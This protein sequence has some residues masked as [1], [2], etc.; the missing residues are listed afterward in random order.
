MLHVTSDHKHGPVIVGALEGAA[1]A[2]VG[3]GVLGR[4][5]SEDQPALSVIDHP[6]A[7]PPAVLSP[8]QDV[9]LLQT[10]AHE[11]YTSGSQ[12]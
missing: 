3:A 2:G 12:C 8:R 6:R 7:Q 4:D 5:A 1:G 9:R 11:C 10:C